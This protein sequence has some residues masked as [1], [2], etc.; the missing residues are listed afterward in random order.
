MF[1]GHSVA[2]R[3]LGFAVIGG[4]ITTGITFYL[5]KN[6]KD[7]N[8][9]SSHRSARSQ[10]D[11]DEIN[12]IEDNSPRNKQI[13]DT[14]NDFPPD[15]R[16][17]IHG[18]AGVVSKGIDSK[19]FFDALTRIMADAYKFAKNGGDSVTGTIFI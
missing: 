4:V 14:E 13:S 2:V 5:R 10:S 16:V 7:R 15:F 3:V 8:D 1:A 11:Y 19:P 12:Q 18:G 9:S 6:R 17:I